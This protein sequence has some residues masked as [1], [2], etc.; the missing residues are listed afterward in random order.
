[1]QALVFWATVNLSLIFLEHINFIIQNILKIL[2]KIKIGC[3]LNLAVFITL[4][5][6]LDFMPAR[7]IGVIICKNLKDS[8]P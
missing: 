5:V 8:T 7:F 6:K 4:L 1:V 2:R 3:H